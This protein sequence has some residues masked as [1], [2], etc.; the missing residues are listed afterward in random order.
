MRHMKILLAMFVLY[1]M[2]NMSPAGPVCPNE[3]Q[4][5]CQSAATGQFILQSD[6]L[7][8]IRR[9]DDFRPAASVIQQICYFPCFLG[10]TASGQS[11]ECTGGTLG[12]TPPPDN[13]VAKFYADDFGK[14]GVLVQ[15]VP[16]NGLNLVVESKAHV[17]P[18]NRCW[19]YTS[20]ILPPTGLA[21][22]AGEC[23]WIEVTGLGEAQANGICEVYS[24]SNADGNQYSMRD[25][26]ESYQLSDF[27]RKDLAFCIDGGIMG[28]SNPPASMDGGCGDFP[29]AC[30]KPGPSCVDGGTYS[31]CV[32]SNPAQFAGL[33]FPYITCAELAV[34]GGCPIP[35]NDECADAYVPIECTNQVPNPDLGVCSVS[36]GPPNIMEVCDTT[37]GT[38]PRH[39]CPNPSATCGPLPP[40]FG[41]Y[42]CQFMTDNRLASTD[43]PSSSGEGC[44]T[45]GGGAALTVSVRMSGTSTSRHVAVL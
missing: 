8:G 44:T 21:V 23:M 29:V 11:F 15:G 24:L 28:A 2:D 18:G 32:G 35:P 34:M 13:F 39:D 4:A 30:C 14:P 7:V 5:H 36:E 38:A 33:P 1:G 6:R 40:N 37:I 45:C 12:G 31:E 19:R 10:A 27:D 42:R 41:A 17:S 9:A 20:P 22:T 26:N 3:D 43:G 25:E 16:A